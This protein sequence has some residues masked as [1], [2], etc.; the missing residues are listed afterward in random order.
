MIALLAFTTANFFIGEISDLGVKGLT[1]FCPGSLLFSI[2]YFLYNREWAKKNVAERGMLDQ[3]EG[4]GHTRK[5]LLRTW[6][7]KF[8]WWSLFIVCCGS[9]FQVG[10]YM[11][12]VL[13]YFMAHKATLNIGIAQAVWSIN[14]FFISIFERVF[15]N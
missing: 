14:P 13:T 2:C 4:E 9:V 12:I 3:S 6:D 8:D 1:Y 7:N 10:I 15:Y 5:V 11:A